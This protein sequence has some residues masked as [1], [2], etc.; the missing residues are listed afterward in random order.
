[1]KALFIIVA[2]VFTITGCTK[3]EV[4]TKICDTGKK[5]ATLITAEVAVSLDC[6][7]TAAI[8]AD[9]EKRLV[10]LKVC[11]A[12]KPAATTS[13]LKTL[14]AIGDVVCK[15]VVDGLVAGLLTQ[16]PSAWECKGGKVSDELKLKL[17]EQCSKVL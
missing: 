10:D 14:G 6:A 7:N 12:P 1:M 5:A 11:E 3:E 2:L 9:I 15:P 13:S 8:Q 17:L 4:K 16:V